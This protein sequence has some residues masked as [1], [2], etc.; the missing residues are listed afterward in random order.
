MPKITQIQP[1]VCVPSLALGRERGHIKDEKGSK[2]FR[3]SLQMWLRQVMGKSA[4]LPK[5]RVLND[6]WG[7]RRWCQS[8]AGSLQGIRV[9]WGDIYNIRVSCIHCSKEKAIEH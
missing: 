1:L 8:Q 3:K 5:I 9:F 7:L 6:I 2:N 4:V